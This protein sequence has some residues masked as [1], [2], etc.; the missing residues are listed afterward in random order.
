MPHDFGEPLADLLGTIREAFGSVVSGRAWQESKSTFGLAHYIRSH[1]C[2]VG[3]SGWHPH[4]HI[5]LFAITRLSASE[6][7]ELRAKLHSRWEAAV[8][9]RGHRPPS[10]EHG[11][12]LE[13]ARNR[14]DVARYVCQVV[15]GDDSKPA[16]VA[17]EVARGD[18]KTSK[19]MGYRTPFEVLASF[20]ESGDLAELR[21]WQEWERATHGVHAIRW[22][23]GLRSAISLTAEKT[24]AE[25][26]A[27]EIGGELVYTFSGYEWGAVCRARGARSHILDHAERGGPSAVASYVSELL[28]GTAGFRPTSR[29]LRPTRGNY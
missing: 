10:L 21:L 8:V 16:A 4:L 22:S 13:Q 7:L 27:V 3:P 5:V 23:N 17:M 6:I 28:N 26:V 14:S 18:L 1:D 19:H 12:H 20:G 24:D 25:I 29:S 9:K 2:T 11:I 15:I